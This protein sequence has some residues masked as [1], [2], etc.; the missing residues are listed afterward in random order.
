MKLSRFVQAIT[1][2]TLAV[3][4]SLFAAPSTPTNARPAWVDDF[5]VVLTWDDVPEATAFAVYRYDPATAQWVI[6]G[7]DV[8]TQMF[9]EVPPHQPPLQ[10][11]ITAL[12]A[13]GESSAA[14]VSIDTTGYPMTMITV[15]PP[16][17]NP[18]TLTETNALISF[19]S[20]I[21]SGTDG[22][23]E[24]GTSPNALEYF[25]YQPDYAGGHNF[26]VTN[27][28]P[29]TE[30]FYR[31]TVTETSRLGFSYMNS[32][33]TYPMNQPP[34]A[35]DVTVQQIGEWETAI[36]VSGSDPDF[37]QALIMR[38][39]TDPTNGTIS[40]IGQSGPDSW[41]VYYQ[42]NPRARGT[43]TFQF[44]ISDGQLES[45]PA[46]V[47]IT[48][49]FMNEPPVAVD[50]QVATI[51]DSAVAVTLQAD[52]ADGD[53]LTYV[54]DY[55]SE[56]TLTGTAPNLTW[57]P[58]ANFNGVAWLSFH[59]TDGTETAYGTVQFAVSPVNDA[60]VAYAQTYTIQEDVWR[61]ITFSATD[62]EN[63]PVTFE[64]VSLPTH[65]TLIGSGTTRTYR[66]D[67]NY[68]GTDSFRYR[69][70]DGQAHSATV[71][72][73]IVIF[74]VND[75]PVA[76]NQALSVAEDNDLSVLLTAAD[77]DGGPN[78][79]AIE[80]HPQHGTLTGSGANLVYTPDVNYNGTDSFDFR[81]SGFVGA[82]LGRI[83]INVAPVND[84][85][86]AD[87]TGVATAYNTPV[88]FTLSGSDVEGTA[89][90]FVVL[91]A[92]TNGTLSGTAPNLTFTP[93]I[94]WS[95]TTSFIFEV[96]DGALQSSPATVNITIAPAAAAPNAPSG[97]TATAVSRSQINLTW[98]D[99][100][101]NEDGFRIER[102]SNNTWTQIG[103]VEPDVRSFSSTGLSAN[104]SYSYR[105]RAFNMR[106]NSAYSNTAS[107]KTL[108]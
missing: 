80:S 85:P 102:G 28:L 37:G 98:N 54:V 60:P 20:S 90:S 26:T 91:T 17:L 70:F 7:S 13:E 14:I 49:I 86:V 41:T 107:A 64:I 101:N 39:S 71:T 97:L 44:V 99:N 69:A 78:E 3:F 93:A 47:T 15:S 81:V 5:S 35:Q 68:F 77:P 59:V 84:A 63:E 32:F 61:T 103:T 66:P 87:E 89:L 43:D 8:L 46:T 34:T 92:P 88:A 62:V 76:L 29:G 19:W 10:Y 11:A 79:F 22:L 30:Y 16:G 74:G 24:I 1:L 48:D 31:L 9:R 45:A 21:I 82:S 25:E 6:A 65:G 38:I 94:G 18:W 96:N 105:V 57:T 2:A 53:A 23:L 40:A 72:V 52:D 4:N 50:S 42:P 75:Q 104:K 73:S 95:G 83:D 100:S 33:V 36:T 27:L 55:L 108:R 58:A 12:N 106:G 56:G 51:E 67:T